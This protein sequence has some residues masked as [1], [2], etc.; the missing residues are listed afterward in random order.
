[1]HVFHP[2]KMR[3]GILHSA[4]TYSRGGVTLA[5]DK[6][7]ILMKIRNCVDFILLTSKEE[8]LQSSERN[9]AFKHCWRHI[10]SLVDT[11]NPF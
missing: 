11:K 4:L 9:I 3:Q 5:K 1:M 8:C 7:K 2:K 10:T 6:E